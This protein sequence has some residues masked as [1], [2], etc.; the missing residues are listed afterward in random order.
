[1]GAR[2]RV[3]PMIPTVKYPP[4][5]S[6]RTDHSFP[7]AGTGPHIGATLVKANVVPSEALR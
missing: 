5:R 6:P 7:I 2:F 4:R 3:N 1:M